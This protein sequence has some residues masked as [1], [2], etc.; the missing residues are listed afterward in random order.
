[1]LLWK[2]KV[3]DS[4]PEEMFVCSKLLNTVYHEYIYLIKRFYFIY[5]FNG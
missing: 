4:V 1:M 3:A 5:D 2:F